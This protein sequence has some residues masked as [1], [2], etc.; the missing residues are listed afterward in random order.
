MVD[1][2]ELR[3]WLLTSYH[4]EYFGYT[5][6]NI[7]YCSIFD[8]VIKRYWIFCGSFIIADIAEDTQYRRYQYHL[9]RQGL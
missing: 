9:H 8:N 2:L 3:S 5:Q 6:L 7:I 4:T 1:L